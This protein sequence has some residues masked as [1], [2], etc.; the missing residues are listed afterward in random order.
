M[1]ANQELYNERRKRMQAAQ[2][3]TE[4]DRVP[5]VPKMNFF[6][7]AAYGINNYTTMNDL[8]NIVPGLKAYL[9]EFKPDAVWAPAQYGIPVLEHLQPNFIHWPGY[10]HKIGLD[11]SFQILDDEYMTVDEYDEFILD[12]TNFILTKWLPR[13]HKN[14][15]GLSKLNFQNGIELGLF[16]LMAPF[17]DPEVKLAVEAMLKAGEKSAEWLAANGLF[18]ETCVKEGFP[19]GPTL[20]QTCPFDMLA[21]NYRGMINCIMDIKERPE[22]LLEALNVMTELCLKNALGGLKAL[23]HDYLFIPLHMGVDEFMSPEDYA[24][25]YWPGLRA[26]MMAGIEQGLTPYVFCEG[27]YNTRLE[28][29]CDV[30]EGKVIYMFEKVDMKKAKETVGKVACICGNLPTATMIFGTPDKVADETKKLLD[31]CAPGGGFIMDC[32]IVIDN[33]PK[34]NLHAMFD[35]TLK[36]GVYK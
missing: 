14:L 32:S 15:A 26:L 16:G 1:S 24:K 8:R 31:I 30:P 21:D 6:Y 4:A 34:E 27:N 7:G 12:P 22:Q 36:Y 5:V 20:G 23:G 25:F 10:E 18:F 35:T 19:L 33:C 28:Q 29:L 11:Q 2:A 3:L 13:R 17:A 9:N